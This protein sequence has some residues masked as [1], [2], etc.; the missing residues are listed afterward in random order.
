MEQK[1]EPN[2]QAKSP[3]PA[4]KCGVCVNF[5]PVPGSELDGRCFGAQVTAAGLCDFFTAKHH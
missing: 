1:I 3:D 5:Q 4:R 2:Y